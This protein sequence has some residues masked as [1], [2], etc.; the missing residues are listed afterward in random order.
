MGVKLI[1]SDA[2][3][4]LR[5]LVQRSF[6]LELKLKSSISKASQGLKFS[7]NAKLEKALVE[8]KEVRQ[9]TENYRLGM[10]KLLYNEALWIDSDSD[11]G[12]IADIYSSSSGD[13]NGNK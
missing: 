2:K 1:D 8:C 10:E 5:N 4:Y 9:S 3:G 11:P 6:D 13:W 12:A 7:G